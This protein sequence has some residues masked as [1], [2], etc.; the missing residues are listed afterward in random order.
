M[1]NANK[2]LKVKVVDD[3]LVISIG[4]STLAYALQNGPEPLGA[5]I[6]NAKAFAKDVAIRLE[7]DSSSR[8]EEGGTPLVDL[9]W[10]AAN[11]AIEYGSVHALLDGDPSPSVYPPER[12]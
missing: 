9:L 8:G 2:P 1:K 6:R 5:S 11:S 12:S 4:V 10:D 7:N 3:Q